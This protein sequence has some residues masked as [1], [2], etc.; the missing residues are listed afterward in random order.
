MSD[1]PPEDPP[2][3]SD[4][5]GPV[6]EAKGAVGPL[7]DAAPGPVGAEISQTLT[8]DEPG[9]I[10][11]P[12]EGTAP[13][14]ADLPSL[15]EGDSQ[16]SYASTSDFASSLEG[17][18]KRASS[19]AK[20]ALRADEAARAA[21][22]G[23]ALGILLGLTM[24]SIV[25]LGGPTWLVVA[26]ELA[27]GNL[28]VASL[29][30]A[31]RSE[32]PRH[33]TRGL[34]RWFAASCVA[35]SWVVQL[36]LGV[37][38][39]TALVVTLGISFI[40]TGWDRS[41]ALGAPI[42]AALG[43]F[44]MA[45]AITVGLFDDPGRMASRDVLTQ[46]RFFFT[47]MAPLV[48]VLTAWV[49]RQGRRILYRAISDAHESALLA[50]MR[51]AQLA[52]VKQDLDA[53]LAAGRG[54]GG[55]YTGAKMGGY[56]LGALIG[57]G[58]MGEVYGAREVESKAPAAVKL[59]VQGVTRQ[60]TLVAR[61][62]QEAE[63]TRGL[64]SPHIVSVLETGS[65]PDGTPFIVMERLEG[66]DLGW[67]L[68]RKGTFSV[69]DALMLVEHVGRGLDAAH[70]A[71]IVHRD[72]KPRNLFL[73][74]RGEELWKI[75]DFGVSKARDSSGTLTQSGLVGTPSYMSPEQA[76]AADVDGRADVFGLGAVLYRVLTGRRPF[77][78][79]SPAQVLYEV[80]HH[81]PLRPSALVPEIPTQVE[82]VVAIALAKHA[83]HRFASGAQFFHA[84]ES[85]A[86]G[87]LPKARID[88][89][90]RILKA[91]PWREPGVATDAEDS[92]DA[93]ALSPA[94]PA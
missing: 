60:K 43:Y 25:W 6:E 51:E 16:D 64:D 57:R 5:S 1:R 82:Y 41:W 88:R 47:F 24:I 56:E 4:A 37:F 50:G 36:Y 48:M 80:V 72:I 93:P 38:S 91:H 77:A 40:A 83:R 31:K 62:H 22:F 66:H 12:H 46:T 26:T 92:G 90:R 59:L 54:V 78:G 52:E 65:A 15:S 70:A 73:D 71:G 14:L 87:K 23:R 61:F 18:S 85:A 27:L 79:E 69:A 76:E 17:V 42:V 67:H 86:K 28:M 49:A 32:D 45:L 81:Q 58:A 19:A 10:E 34:F 84:L 21:A 39:P 11:E 30:T 74:D 29:W 75:L 44:V 55:R 68:R 3:E 89:A 7:P 94:S 63:I 53:A 8:L 9:P 20:R 2:V 33:Y 35:A 13:S